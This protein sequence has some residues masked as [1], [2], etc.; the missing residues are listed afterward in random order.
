M[1]EPFY[2]NTT[3]SFPYDDHSSSVEEQANVYV[4]GIELSFFNAAF[5]QLQSRLKCYAQRFVPSET[6][7][8]IVAETFCNWWRSGKSFNHINP[9]SSYLFVAV[10]HRCF[11]LL[12]LQKKENAMLV[13]ISQP[14]SED[15][16]SVKEELLQKL[17]TEIA[18]LPPQC[19]LIFT[20]A[21]FEQLPEKQI[22]ARLNIS[23]NT[24]RNQ[25]ARALQLLRL[26]LRLVILFTFI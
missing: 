5:E 17:E 16:F 15:D 7:E 3:A 2:Q 19:K 8:D 20:L 23:P 18:H 26:A 10:R 21:H 12:E 22:A 11:K 6:A 13:H 14:A 25:K 24:V 9:L 4:T 1:R